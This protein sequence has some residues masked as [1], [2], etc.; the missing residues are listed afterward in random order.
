MN[1]GFPLAEGEANSSVHTILSEI[2][3][4]VSGTY[5]QSF[6]YQFDAEGYPKAFIE[7]DSFRFE[8]TRA[9][10]KADGILADVKII[11]KK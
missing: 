7:T 11:K 5:I 3:E 2:Y 1:I 10:L 4:N 8:F 9:S 6:E